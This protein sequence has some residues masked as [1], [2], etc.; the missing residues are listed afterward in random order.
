[1]LGFAQ[2]VFSRYETG[3]LR[4]DARTSLALE[5][6]ICRA[7]SA[8]QD[9]DKHHDVPDTTPPAETAPG[10]VE[11]LTAAPQEKAAWAGLPPSPLTCNQAR[12]RPRRWSVPLAGRKQPPR[13][14][15]IA[16]TGYPIS[17]CPM[18]GS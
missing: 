6:I 2:S 8:A 12:R 14:R 16:R 17:G 13:K 10:K 9:R 1:M 15:A 7:A 4:L 3:V 18:W 11:Q 5:A